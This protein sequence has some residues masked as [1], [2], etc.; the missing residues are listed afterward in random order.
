M[1]VCLCKWDCLF[2]WGPEV[3]FRTEKQ[4]QSELVGTFPWFSQVQVLFIGGFRELKWEWSPCKNSNS[5]LC[6]WMCEHGSEYETGAA[7][8]FIS[9]EPCWWSRMEPPVWVCVSAC[10]CTC[11]GIFV[12]TPVQ[13]V[14]VCM[15]IPPW[16]RAGWREAVERSG[17]WWQTT[18]KRGEPTWSPENWHLY[19][20]T[21]T[22]PEI[23]H[24]RH[25]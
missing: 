21:H 16:R 4:V 2:L 1:C 10:V 12:C 17:H 22:H 14:C 11:A 9:H 7:K 3:P 5:N 18:E 13:C 8:S 19:E 24:Y 23:R 25:L 15:H 20:H 6:V